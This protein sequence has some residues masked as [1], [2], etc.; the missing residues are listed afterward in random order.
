MSMN[1]T[2]A[3]VLSHINN[4]EQKNKLE[5]LTKYSSKITKR[6]LYSGIRGDRRFKG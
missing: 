6:K 3:A 4:Y 2:L 5:V 1:D